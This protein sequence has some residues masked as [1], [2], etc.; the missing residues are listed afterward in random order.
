MERKTEISFHPA[1][2]ALLIF[3]GKFNSPV[4]RL[5]DPYD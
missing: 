4:H 1:Q 3:S 2:L 5:T